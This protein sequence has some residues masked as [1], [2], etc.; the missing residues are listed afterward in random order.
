L[1]SFFSLMLLQF[2]KTYLRFVRDLIS[3]VATP[4]LRTSAY[5]F[6]A[7]RHSPVSPPERWFYLC[8]H[9][10]ITFEYIVVCQPWC[11][12]LSRSVILSLLE[13]LASLRAHLDITWLKELA[14]L[15][16]SVGVVCDSDTLGLLTWVFLY[17]MVVVIVTS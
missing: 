17:K 9:E 2:Y 8:F 3:I 15:H 6:W 7:H 10:Q 13:Y 1:T 12:K 16:I 5:E 11:S 4:E 14:Y